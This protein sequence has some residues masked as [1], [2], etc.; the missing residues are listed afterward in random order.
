[1]VD[2]RRVAQQLWRQRQVRRIAPVGRDDGPVGAIGCEDVLR[3]AILKAAPH[4]RQDCARRQAVRQEGSAIL[5]VGRRADRCTDRAKKRRCPWRDCRLEQSSTRASTVTGNTRQER[6]PHSLVVHT[7]EGTRALSTPR[8]LS[9]GVR[10]TV[11][12]AEVVDPPQVKVQRVRVGRAVQGEEELVL[13]IPP[14]YGHD[15]QSHGYAEP[16]RS[17]Q[18][19]AHHV[20]DHIHRRLRGGHALLGDRVGLPGVL[21]RPV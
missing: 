16:R 2:D 14:K 17:A 12:P 5:V 6:R 10:R 1:M 15:I 18:Y 9:Q 13:L 20:L 21:Q 3:H 19:G 11:L 7:A 8:A 4:G